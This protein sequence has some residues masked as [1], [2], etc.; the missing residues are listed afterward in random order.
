MWTNYAISKAIEAGWKRGMGL[1][2]IFITGRV[3]SV[4]P[5]KVM[6]DGGARKLT[7]ARRIDYP[8]NRLPPRK[9]RKKKREEGISCG[10]SGI[11]HQSKFP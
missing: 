10:Q 2:N 6:G 1:R 5:Q 9:F 4:F 3:S 11:S 8:N 7:M